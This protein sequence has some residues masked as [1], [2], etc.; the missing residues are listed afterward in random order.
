MRALLASV[1]APP[2]ASLPWRLEDL[3]PGTQVRYYSFAR[4]A[5]AEGLRAAGLG[6]A[7][8]V[9][10][11]GF[12]CRDVLSSLAAVGASAV[13]YPVDTQMRPAT[14]P[15]DWPK[16]DAV[17]AVDYFGFPQDLAPFKA[18]CKPTSAVLIEDNAH[19]L[20]SRDETGALLGSRGDLGLFSLR[21]TLPLPNG[22]ALAVTA[23]RGWKVPEQ[24]AF[25]AEADLRR[26]MKTG[27]RLLAGK[28]GS[29]RTLQGLTLLRDLRRLRTGSR[30][31]RPDPRSEK[32]LP[33]PERP[34]RALA[35]PLTAADPAAEAKRRRA[36]YA[37]LSPRLDKAGAELI[38]DALPH[39]VVPYGLPFRAEGAALTKTVAL[40]E[41]LGLE[42]S[43]WPDLPAAVMPTAPD[44]YKNVRIVHFLW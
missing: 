37:F 10:L 44:F 17:L 28:L 4:R 42:P 29:R 43:T 13:F 16:A 30:L 2:A 22:A 36:L 9:L 27:S 18:Y 7:S 32:E 40:L 6:R 3:L 39:G 11:P 33:S 1:Y 8:K 14:S 25:G 15:E 24:G 12:L 38:F 23:Q 34:C 26:L 19:G 5:L 20:F 41:S 35:R 31:P 21:K